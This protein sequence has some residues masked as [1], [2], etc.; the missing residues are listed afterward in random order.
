MSILFI[1]EDGGA[2][3]VRKIAIYF[4][5]TAQRVERRKSEEEKAIMLQ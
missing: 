5:Q 1:P 4:Y 3:F 2:T